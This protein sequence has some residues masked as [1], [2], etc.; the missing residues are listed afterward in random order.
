[1][2]REGFRLTVIC[3]NEFDYATGAT[4]V[5]ITFETTGEGV[6]NPGKSIGTYSVRVSRFSSSPSDSSS[7]TIVSGNGLGDTIVNLTTRSTGVNV[8]AGVSEGT[9][10]LD[11]E[12][13]RIGTGVV[14]PCDP[15][16]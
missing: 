4:L 8:A 3:I 10:N 12:A 16:P 5:N 13:T 14:A 11:G 7:S 15:G 6:P 9:I 2:Y 1:M